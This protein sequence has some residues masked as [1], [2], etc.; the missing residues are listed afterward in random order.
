MDRDRPGDRTSLVTGFG[1]VLGVVVYVLV[2]PFRC[3]SGGTCDGLVAFHYQPGSPGHWQ[4]IGAAALVGGTG[5]LLLWLVVGSDTRGH[6]LSKLL[7]TPL[8]LVGIGVSVLSQ[9][10]LFVA[11]PLLGGIV[12]WLMW[13]P[14][15]WR[16]SGNAN[17]EPGPFHSRR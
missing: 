13:F 3:S 16:V 15:P 1:V 7:M 5:A 17:P 11:G 8:L 10:L 4:A 2:A 12:L 6:K 9:S 14:P